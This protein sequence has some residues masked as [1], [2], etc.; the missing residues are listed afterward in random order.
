MAIEREAREGT[1]E[2][3][4]AGGGRY[5]FLHGRAK[6][7]LLDQGGAA[8]EDALIRHV[9]GSGGAPALWRP[10]LRQLLGAPES[11]DLRPDGYWCLLGYAPPAGEA[12]PL[13]DLPYVVVDVETTGLKP[14]RQRVIEVAAVRVRG[15]REE[16]VFSSLLQPDRRLPDYVAGLTKISQ[17]MLEEAPR[18]AALVDALLAFLG[19]D[20]LVGH[21]VGFDLAFLDAELRRVHRPALLNPRLD[22]LPLAVHLLPDLRRPALDRIA[23]SLGLDTPQRHRAE[24]DARLTAAVLARLLPLARERGLH[25]LR[26]LQRV[27]GSPGAQ[28]TR[29]RADGLREAVGRG[30]AVLDRALLVDIPHRPGCYLMRDARGAVIYVG[31]A[32]DLRDRV[33]SYYSQPLGYT[34]KLDGLLEAIAAIETVVTGSELE[35]LLLESQLIRRYTPR[36]NIVGRNYEHYPYIKVDLADAWPRVYATKRRRDDGGRYFGPFRDTSAVRR[37]IELLTDLLP[38]RTCRPRAATPERRW[39]PCLRL[40]LGKCL[41]PCTGATTPEEYGALVADVIRFLDGDAAG[42]VA[43]LWAQLEAAAARLDFERAAYLRNALRVVQQ[44][45]HEGAILNGAVRTDDLLLA[46]PSAEE[47]AV[48]ALLLA[49]GRLWAQFRVGRDE[50]ATA[51]AARLRRAWERARAA[52]PLPV[53]HESVD[54][55]NLLARWLHRHHGALRTFALP[56]ADDPAAWHGLAAALL[57]CDP[58]PAVWDERPEAGEETADEAADGA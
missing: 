6:A 44:V 15:G 37:T 22:V 10:L 43:R 2:A 39:P 23:A 38:L 16:A 1:A 31:K 5:A 17:A 57:A 21:N 28:G 11:F 12:T 19:D 14:T 25:S 32:K 40:S 27:A 24:A 46:L 51:V 18:F 49:R 53:D 41:G 42:V 34:R 52:G 7:F 58:A 30:R 26:D 29:E 55:V 9:F 8:H 33:G 56:A 45:A 47:G 13:G 54:E 4:D 50:D 35:A 3:G 36:Y 20:L 48:E